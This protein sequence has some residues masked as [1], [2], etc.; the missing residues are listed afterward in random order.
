MF[1]VFCCCLFISLG[2]WGL[3]GGVKC[4]FGFFLPFTV[5]LTR[6]A[7]VHTLIYLQIWNLFFYIYFLLKFPNVLYRLTYHIYH[8]SFMHS[9]GPGY[10]RQC[11]Y[12][13]MNHAIFIFIYRWG[14]AILMFINFEMNFIHS[15]I[16]I[17][18][19]SYMTR[20][21]LK[22]VTIHSTVHASIPTTYN[23]GV[24]LQC[25]DN[26]IGEVKI[27]WPFVLANG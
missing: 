26:V 22:F 8:N 13:F 6:S 18:Y 1:G 25:V 9:W 5:T 11:Q 12:L 24:W 17:I 15:L 7:A 3:G 20:A 4:F 14:L 16:A 10:H 23:Y 21:K 19:Y 27:I 2:G